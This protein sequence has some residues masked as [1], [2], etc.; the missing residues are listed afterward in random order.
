MYDRYVRK[1][2]VSGLCLTC[3][4]IKKVCLTKMSIS[5]D[6]EIGLLN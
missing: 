2:N 6:M 4:T 5:L 1:L 3:I